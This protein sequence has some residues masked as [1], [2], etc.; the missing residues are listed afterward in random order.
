MSLA[1]FQA[2]VMAVAMAQPTQVPALEALALPFLSPLLL[3]AVSQVPTMEAATLT[4]A[5]T[6]SLIPPLAPVAFQVPTMDPRLG[7]SRMGPEPPAVL[8]K[9]LVS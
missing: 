4:L 2:L 7:S 3:A 8:E 6:P 5:L 1:V 9:L